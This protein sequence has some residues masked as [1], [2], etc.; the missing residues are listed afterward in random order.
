MIAETC[1]QSTRKYLGRLDRVLLE[2]ELLW[3]T[4]EPTN[5]LNAFRESVHC[6]ADQCRNSIEAF[7]KKAKKYGPMVAPR[8]S[9]RMRR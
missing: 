8:C 9:F 1:Q 3:K 7:L 2:V 6:K 4:C 5:E